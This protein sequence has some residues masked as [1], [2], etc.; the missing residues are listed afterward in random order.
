M[1]QDYK[2]IE[3]WFGYEKHYD[4]VM[5]QLTQRALKSDQPHRKITIVEIGA[6]LGRSSFY[7]VDKHAGPSANKVYIVDTWLGSASEIDT[8]HSLAKE[9]NIYVEFMRNMQKLHGRFTPIRATSVE[10]ANIFENGTV[11]YVFIDGEHTYEAVK[12]DIE[13]WL[14]KM[15]T[16]GIMA[17][18]DY[19]DNWP[20]VVK[21]VGE[22]FGNAVKKDSDIWI[23]ENP[24]KWQNQ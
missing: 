8:H 11:D 20:G 5:I 18:H 9:K 6:W 12:A 19:N 13:A 2:E 24:C 23:I 17:G 15:S 7:L 22:K 16:I 3:G 1:I 21:A 4:D 14:P 10:A